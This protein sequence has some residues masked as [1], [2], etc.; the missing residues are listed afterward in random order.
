[1]ADLMPI[2]E[3]LHNVREVVKQLLL[4]EDHLFHP[5][6]RCEDCISK[7]LLTAEAF[8]EE[9]RTLD[10]DQEH[11]DLLS[12]LSKRI[13]SLYQMYQRDVPKPQ[14]AQAARKIRKEL[15]PEAKKVRLSNV[16]DGGQMAYRVAEQWVQRRGGWEVV[17]H[18][19]VE[20][21]IKDWIQWVVQPLKVILKHHKDFV[22]GPIDDVM[23][24]IIKELAPKLVKAVVEAEVDADVDEFMEGAIKG[25]WDARRGLFKDPDPSQTPDW[26]EGYHWGYENPDKV[27]PGRIP[28][29][30][31][32]KLVE[33]GLSEARGKITEATVVR[34]LKSAWHAISPATT[35]KA[36]IRAIKKHGWKLGVAMALMEIA[37]HFIIPAVLSKLTGN[38]KFLVLST[39]P[40]SEIIYAVVL[41]FLGRMPHELDKPD[42]DGH[43]DWYESRYGPVRIAGC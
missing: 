30:L 28:A 5:E 20:A 31:K 18:R 32:K 12:D 15:M 8:A 41:R 11:V 2:M 38:P 24:E 3:P 6:R 27:K 7:H 39:L 21:G 29:P 37:E 14:I 16:M 13:R 42:P 36:V 9:A 26:I 1:M 4:L 34:L 22:Y 43:L 25:R 33:E 17:A 23:D 19:S 10:V 40:I 35:I